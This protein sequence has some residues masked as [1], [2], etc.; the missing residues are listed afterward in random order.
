MIT[1]LTGTLKQQGH[2]ITAIRRSNGDAVIIIGTPDNLVQPVYIDH[3]IQ[4]QFM[5]TTHLVILIPRVRLRSH[6]NGSNPSAFISKETRLTWLLS[7]PCKD[8]PVDEQSQLPSATTSLTASSIFLSRALCASLAS[9]MITYQW[10]AIA[11]TTTRVL[12]IDIHSIYTL[13]YTSLK[14]IPTPRPPHGSG[15]AKWFLNAHNSIR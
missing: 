14:I 13:I 10:T 6:R 8:M 5:V 9:N 3:M 2:M 11:T 12:N 4:W 7:I 15:Q 1:T